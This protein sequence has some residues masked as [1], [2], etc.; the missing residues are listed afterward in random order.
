MQC[1]SFGLFELVELKIMLHKLIAFV[2]IVK[3]KQNLSNIRNKV[4]DL[5]S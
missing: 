1:K 5:L 2:S 4:L 3:N